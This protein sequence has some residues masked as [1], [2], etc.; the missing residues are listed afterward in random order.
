MGLYQIDS[1]KNSNLTAHL[2]LFLPLTRAAEEMWSLLFVLRKP[3]SSLV[4]SDK[5]TWLQALE[6]TLW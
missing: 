3:Q 5:P 6:V 4:I 1:A 2:R